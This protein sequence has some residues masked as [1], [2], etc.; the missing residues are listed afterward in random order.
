MSVSLNRT[1]NALLARGVPSNVAAALASAGHT[2]TSLNSK[3]IEQLC[4]L[5]LSKS[6]ARDIHL[7]RTAVPEATLMKLLFDNKWV[8]C[9]C[10]SKTE[11]VVVHH[12]T[13]WV[14]S[15]SH[16]PSNLVVLCPNDHAKAHVKGDLSQSLTPDRL[17]IIKREWESQVKLDDSEVLRLAAQNVGEYWYFFNLLR[18]HEIAEHESINLQ[19]LSHY[20]AARRAQLLDTSG[21]LVSE[22]VSSMYAYS[23]PHAMLRYWY[24]RDLFLRVLD[25]LSV[26]NVSDRLDRSDLGNTVIRND[27]VYVEGAHFFK[28]LNNVS[29]GPGQLVRGTRSAN[30]IHFNF[31]FDRWYATSSSAH[32]LWLTGR[33]VV[34]CFCRVGDVSRE[35]G[36]IV[37]ACTVLAICT[38]LPKQRTRSYVSSSLP[39][40]GDSLNAHDGKFS[41]DDLSDAIDDSDSFL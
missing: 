1:K 15:R 10:R 11:P 18:L 33:R 19:S 32:S 40:R 24:A 37:I 35:L 25:R 26:T 39:L 6:V 4:S 22:D 27:I 20:S 3:S 14:E 9:V 41:S 36:K 16:E 5:G 13:P 12:I 23:G 38:E 28:R 34:G 31:T 7:R 2:I 30:S 8:C 17:R 21:R 29:A